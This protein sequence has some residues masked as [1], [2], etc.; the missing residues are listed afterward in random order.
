MRDHLT[1]EQDTVMIIPL[2]GVVQALAHGSGERAIERLVRES[3][4]AVG[5]DMMR[6]R[7]AA[8]LL[9]DPGTTDVVD[10]LVCGE[11]LLRVPSVLITGDPG[12][13]RRLLDGDPRGPRVAV[14][15]V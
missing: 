10:A 14:W 9:R 11:A 4:D 2:V 5:P 13:M 6:A 12:A 8:H 1:T 15:G 3:L 7:L